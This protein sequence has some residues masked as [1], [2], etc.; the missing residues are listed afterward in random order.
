MIAGSSARVLAGVNY[1]TQPEAL[2]GTMCA[3]GR[4]FADDVDVLQ[5]GTR[6]RIAA[7]FSRSAFVRDDRLGLRVRQ[8]ELQRVLT[9]QREQRHGDKA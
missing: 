1:P 3:G 6:S 8:P 7:S 5:S 9:E 4:M 2:G